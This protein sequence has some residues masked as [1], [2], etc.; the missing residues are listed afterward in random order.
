[1]LPIT[2]PTSQVLQ[3]MYGVQ[4][5]QAEFPKLGEKALAA[6]GGAG[7]LTLALGI[8]GAAIAVTAVA[9]KLASK[10]IQA[11]ADAAKNAITRQIGAL[12]DYYAFAATATSDDVLARYEE[13]QVRKEM[14]TQL[15]TDLVALR[16]A[17]KQG[18]V[19]A[20][21]DIVGQVA[22]TVVRGLDALGKLD[23]GMDELND[24]IDDTEQAILKDRSALGLLYEALQ[25]AWIAAN[26]AAE[27]EI[28]LAEE[29]DKATA[30][31]VGALQGALVAGRTW[32]T[33]QLNAYIESLMDE[34]AAINGVT[35]GTLLYADRLQ[36]IDDLIA[37]YLEV[38][39]PSIQAREADTAAV[40]AQKEALDKITIAYDTVTKGVKAEMDAMSKT[41]D[42]RADVLADIAAAE[43]D[44]A[45]ETIQIAQDHQRELLEA[46]ADFLL[47]RNRDIADHYADLADL[48]ASYY[49]KRGDILAGIGEDL[50]EIAADRLD[51]TRDLN[52]DLSDLAREHSKR[53]RDLARDSSRDIQSAAAR[54]DAVGVYEAQ[55]ARRDALNDE[56]EQYE[57]EKRLRE[58]DFRD[59]L[60]QLDKERTTTLRAGQQKLRD[61]DAQHTKERSAAVAAFNEKLRRED[62]DRQI[63]AQRQQ[64]AY[65]RE[66]AAR[67][68]HYQTTVTGL[69]THQADLEAEYA[70]H[71]QRM[72]NIKRQG[73]QTIEAQTPIAQGIRRIPEYGSGGVPPVGQTVRVGDRGSEL[74]RF[75]A[76]ARVYAHGQAPGGVNVKTGMIQNTFNDVGT[77]SRLYLERMVKQSVSQ[78][79]RRLVGARS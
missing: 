31:Q 40:K 79:F 62:Q 13:V 9:Y 78:E 47:K 75:L 5:L 28:R 18:L 69:Q 2:G 50:G 38:A 17:A 67:L 54:L 4:M 10:E 15:L 41:A 16:D 61:L 55:Q 24:A 39:G 35:G 60:R 7:Q 25:S 36:E 11:G 70:A 72:I 42:A 14:N 32:D 33:D 53:M 74:V 44:Y 6:A 20:E 37:L 34:K 23:Y 68:A 46:E 65:Q 52:R 26:D 3:A 27:A 21:G 45:S 48:D 30:A 71:Y 56:Q 77:T 63:A 57:D 73:E 59:S 1:V 22:A 19:T 76:P 66:D 12:Q 58:R 43:K 51:E 29:R 64:A 49:E 8:A